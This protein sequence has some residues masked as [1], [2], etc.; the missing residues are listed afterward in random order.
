MREKTLIWILLLY[1]VSVLLV[2]AGFL[3][4]TLLALKVEPLMISCAVW[5]FLFAGFLLIF[6]SGRKFLERMG[7]NRVFLAALALSATFGFL[8]LL[9]L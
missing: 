4:L 1:P 8:S 6:L 3:A 2:A 7:A 9:L 5:W